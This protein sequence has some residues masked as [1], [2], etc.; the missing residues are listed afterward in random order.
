MV[1][2]ETVVMRQRF[3]LLVE[4]RGIKTFNR[5]GHSPVHLRAAGRAELLINNLA[6]E[7]VMKSEAISCRF[8][9][10]RFKQPVSRLEQSRFR[11]R[12][13]GEHSLPCSLLANDRG[14]RDDF[15][16][17]LIPT[18]QADSNPVAQFIRRRSRPFARTDPAAAITFNPPLLPQRTHYLLGEEWISRRHAEDVLGQS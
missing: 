13:D 9:D 8:Q 1:R 12:A 10:A 16:L 14:Q 11:E 4:L 6:H 5:L 18:L 2:A 17:Q 15:L 3:N 7:R